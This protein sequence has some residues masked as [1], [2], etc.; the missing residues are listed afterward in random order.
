MKWYSVKKYHPV[1]ECSLTLVRIKSSR[2][3]YHFDLA[4][5][6]GGWKDW[7][8]K[9]FIEEDGYKV[10]HFCIPEPIEIEE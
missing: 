2:D 4:E 3:N 9:D 6:D 5:Y 7:V 8:N 1:L 10:T